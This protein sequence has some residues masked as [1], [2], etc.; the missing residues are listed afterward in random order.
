MRK[1]VLAVLTIA[2]ALAVTAPAHAGRGLIVGIGDQKASFF[3]DPRVEWLGVRHAR[4]VVPWYVA[5]GWN[6]GEL[7]Y[8][9]GWLRAARSRRVQPLLSFGHGF[10]GR[11]RT[12]LPKPAEY[13]GAM[14]AFRKRFP[15][16]RNYIAWNEANHC[17]QP[18]CKKPERAA[19]YYDALKRQCR[20]CT[21]LGASLIDQPNIVTWM[22]RFRKR[23]RFEPSIWGLH[24][25]I[26]VNRLRTT[27]TRRLLRALPK[28][29]RVWITETGGVVYRRHYRNKAAFPES[30]T[31]AGKVTRFLLATA[32]RLPRIDRVYLYHW[33]A[34][35]YQAQWDSGLIDHRG[36][37]RPAFVQLALHLRRDPRK[38][39]WPRRPPPPPPPEPIAHNQ[40]PAQES[41]PPP[42][43]PQ[44][45]PPQEQP[46]QE[47][48]SE[49]SPTEP[50][51]TPTCTIPILC[52]AL[53]PLG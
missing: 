32:L 8:V 29:A 36:V 39:P 9:D 52:P 35:R 20:K 18:T 21:V 47:Q 44:E 19:V 31:H 42:P 11:Q 13:R 26:D 51:T 27:G 3:E 30:E 43:P 41:A 14:R 4:L 37:P 6:R 23:A 16:V 48:P 38:A 5:L 34:D 2:L 45:Q 12:Y 25:Y 24:N 17:S 15:W 49:P 46:Q 10:Y 53:A 33:N 28:R 7:D 40:P 1:G 50:P 22:R